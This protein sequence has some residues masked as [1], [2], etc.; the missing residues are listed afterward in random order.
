M[1]KITN[2]IFKSKEDLTKKWWH[3]LFKVLFILGIVAFSIYLITTLT[4][5]Y[6]QIT[7]QWNYVETF[8]NRLSE[9]PYSGQVFSVQELYSANEVISDEE[10]YEMDLRLGAKGLLLPSNTIM[11]LDDYKSEHYCSN[12]LDKHIEDIA[13][14]NNIE[15]FSDLNPSL[16]GLYS[17]V[18]TFTNYLRNNSYTVDC[19]ILDAYTVTNDDN[20]TSRYRFLK[21]IDT[22]DYTIYEYENHFP[23]FILYILFSVVFFFLSILVVMLIYYKVIMYIIYGKIE[24]DPSE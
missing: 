7:H 22:S 19:V 21:P 11:F 4:N 1:K 14:E 16:G 6:N 23:N 9:E 24:G 18:D 20:T 8:S 13:D 5:S 15:L 2:W 3:R 17:D 12:E 10:S